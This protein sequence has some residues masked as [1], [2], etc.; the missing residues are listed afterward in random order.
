[1]LMA[2]PAWIGMMTTSAA[3]AMTSRISMPPFR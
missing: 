2:T 3:L 1:M